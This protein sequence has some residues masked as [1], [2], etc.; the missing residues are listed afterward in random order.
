MGKIPI[1]EIEDQFLRLKEVFDCKISIVPSFITNNKYN[2]EININP[3]LSSIEKINEELEE[4]K[5]RI[6]SIYQ[7]DVDISNIILKVVLVDCE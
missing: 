7:V 5:K 2:I 6:K 1:E 3:K 4:I